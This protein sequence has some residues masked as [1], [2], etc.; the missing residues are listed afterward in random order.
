MQE[1]KK[2]YKYTYRTTEEVASIMKIFA[3]KK[4]LRINQ[5]IDLALTE[6][7]ARYKDKDDTDTE[8]KKVHNFRI[9]KRTK[10]ERDK[11][12]E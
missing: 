2:D 1:N 9:D 8:I 6:F 4:G 7:I 3:Y 11:K 12:G 5:L 10:E